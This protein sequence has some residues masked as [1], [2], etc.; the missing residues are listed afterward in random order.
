MTV[1]LWERLPTSHSLSLPSVRSPATAAESQAS[2]PSSPCCQETLRPS[3]TEC[4][5]QSTRGV[6]ERR[7]F[8]YKI[9]EVSHCPGTTAFLPGMLLC[10]DM[11]PGIVKATSQPWERSRWI[12]GI[13]TQVLP[14]WGCWANL[15]PL[16]FSWN[17][18]CM[19]LWFKPLPVGPSVTCRWM[20]PELIQSQLKDV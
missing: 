19:F 9:E 20:Y 4:E 10:K 13:L 15:E 17:K 6:W 8:L 11:T 3:H 18:Q 16:G 1:S 2:S 14:S 7:F 5:G 12:T